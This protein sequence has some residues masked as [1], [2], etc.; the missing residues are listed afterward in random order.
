MNDFDP[1]LVEIADQATAGMDRH[2]MLKMALEWE[3]IAQI[4]RL[5]CQA[6]TK[7]RMYV[8]LNHRFSQN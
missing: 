1:E 2:Q 8:G 7:E 5:R 4:I 3:V 6:Q